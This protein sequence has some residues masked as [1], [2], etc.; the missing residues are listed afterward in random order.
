[1]NRRHLIATLALGLLSP[2][3]AKAGDFPKGSPDFKTSYAAALKAAKESGKPLILV[4]S[5]SWCPPCQT[6]KKSVYPSAGVKPYHD[7]FVW[8]CLDADDK[9]NMPAMEKFGVNGIPHIEILNKDGK[10]IGQAIGGTSG[11][12]FAKVLEAAVQK[13]K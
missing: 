9:E 7:K 3:F 6:N 12:A 5:A 10:S 1:M 4:F 2:I 13:S 11:A 8:A